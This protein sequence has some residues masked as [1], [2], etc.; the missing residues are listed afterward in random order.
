LRRQMKSDF[1]FTA[2]GYADL[3]QHFQAMSQRLTEMEGRARL[4]D[5]RFERILDGVDNVLAVTPT[6][7]AFQDVLRR[8][9]ALEARLPAA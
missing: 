5:L 3:S 1:E 8:L 2:A 9:D 4:Q 7:D 6:P